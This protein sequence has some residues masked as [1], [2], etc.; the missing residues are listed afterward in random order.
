MLPRRLRRSQWPSKT[1][2][3]QVVDY[4]T[5]AARA[6]EAENCVG[7]VSRLYG[8]G[9]ELVIKLLDTF[10]QKAELLWI[11]SDRIATPL[12]LRSF[13]TQGA[14]KAVVCF[15]DF[16]S[17]ELAFL[18]IGK[19]LYAEN[20]EQDQQDDDAQGVWSF[21]AGYRFEDLTSGH[22]GEVVEVYDSEMNPLLGVDFGGDLGEVLVPVADELVERIDKKRRKVTMRLAEGLIEELRIR[23]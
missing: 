17:E 12:F 6:V 3:S 1:V 5:R 13:A 19:K 15:E 4:N 7:L 9:G 10:P 21:L 23:D 8:K 18:L 14:S 16:E 11:V 2:I 20:A 22:Q